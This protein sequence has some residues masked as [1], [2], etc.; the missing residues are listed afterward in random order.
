MS[1]NLSLK[2][3]KKILNYYNLPIPTSKK[4]IREKAENIMASKLCKCIKKVK[5]PE[6]RSIGI[7]TKTIFNRKNFTRGKFGC[8]KKQFVNFRKTKKLRK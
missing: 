7:C 6:G 8:R 4:Q 2:D 1:S 5:L 3:Y